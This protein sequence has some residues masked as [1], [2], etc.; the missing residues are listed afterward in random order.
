MPRHDV[1]R[2]FF[3]WE[4]NFGICTTR[5]VEIGEG[6]H[7]VF[8]TDQLIQLHSVSLKEVNYVFPFFLYPNGKLPE[9]EL[10][11]HENGRRPNLSAAFI[12][13]FCEKLKVKFVPNGLGVP[14]K[15]KV[16]DELIFYYAYAI[17]HSTAYR[18]RYA[19]FLRADFPRL[20]LTSNLELFRALAGLGGWLIDLHAR[21]QGENTPV[22]F[23]VKGTDK[24]SAVR[25][26]P[27]ASLVIPGAKRMRSSIPCGTVDTGSWPDLKAGRVW[28]NDR[29]YFEPV[30]EAAWTF[31][32]GGY[33]PAQ[34][35]LKDRIGRSLGFDEKKE[36]QRIVWALVQ[37]KRFMGEIDASINRHGGWPLR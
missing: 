24:V 34:K 22:V 25:F 20:P 16:G 2:H 3:G 31:P 35:W 21:G 15:R 10:F 4:P 37:T 13:D 7:H 1:M 32:I 12:K 26:E 19:E 6:W 23:P 27:V 8:A 33:L 28:I 11:P 29:Q 5:S 18:E 17:F 36:Y 14:D 30:A 9:E